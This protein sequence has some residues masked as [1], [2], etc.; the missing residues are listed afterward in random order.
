M[1]FLGEYEKVS[2]ISRKKIIDKVKLNSKVKID[3]MFL[4]YNLVFIS[5]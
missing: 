4:Q 1:V 3:E 5:I 2:R